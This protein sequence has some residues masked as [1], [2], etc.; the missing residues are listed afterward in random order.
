[1]I[2]AGMVL[3]AGRSRRFGAQNKLLARFRGIPL[4]AHSARAMRL[5]ALDR[6]LAVVADPAVAELFD[7]FDLIWLEGSESEQSDSLRAGAARAREI[8]ADRL[9]VALADM[10]LVPGRLMDGVLDRASDTTPSAASDG[11]C[12]APP[13]CFPRCLF[14]ELENL[15]GDHGA[16]ELLRQL[17]S[18]QLERVTPE[19]LTDIDTVDDLARLDAR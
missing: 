10:P 4:A 5:A 19:I 8:G 14:P 9:L 16:G 18:S 15:R 13:A 6:R 1:M 3:A 2:R 12:C 7:G 11:T 17:P